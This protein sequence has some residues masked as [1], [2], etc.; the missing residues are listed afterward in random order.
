MDLFRSFSFLDEFALLRRVIQVEKL[1]A[2]RE[3]GGVREKP[4]V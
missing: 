2:S 4:R 1:E 3:A